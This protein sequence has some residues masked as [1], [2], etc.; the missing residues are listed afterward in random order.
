MPVNADDAL[1]YSVYNYA[2]LQAAAQADADA[3]LECLSNGADLEVADPAQKT[4]LMLASGRTCRT[5]PAVVDILLRHNANHRHRDARNRI[6]SHDAAA[7]GNSRVLLLLGAAGAALDEVDLDLNTPLHLTSDPRCAAILLAAGARCYVENRAGRTPL[8]EAVLRD[9]VPCAKVHLHYGA[10]P[11]ARNREGVSAVSLAWDWGLAGML[12]LLYG[13][14]AVANADGKLEDFESWLRSA[15]HGATLNPPTI[16]SGA[17]QAP[18]ADTTGPPRA[19]AEVLA[20]P[21]DRD[22]PARPYYDPTEL[23]R[24][25]SGPLDDERPKYLKKMREAG[26]LRVLRKVPEAFSA[27]TLRRDFPN[28]DKVTDFLEKQ[29][30]L[31][32]LAPS[33]VAAFQ[34]ILLLGDPGVGKTRYLLEVAKL[35]RLEFSLIQCGGVS[36]SFVLSGSTT[37]W[38]NGKPGKVHTTL[39]DGSSLNPFVVLDEIDKLSGSHDYDAH[40]PLYQLLEKKTAGRFQDECIEIPMDCSSVIW[41]ATANQLGAIP[42]AIVSRLTVIDVPPPTG[43]G[44]RQ[45]AR[46]VY[47]DILIEHS[48]TWGNRFADELDGVVLDLVKEQTPREIRKCLLGACGNA[49]LRHARQRSEETV[50]TLSPSDLADPMGCRRRPLGFA[51]PTA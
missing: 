16:V 27:D 36:A 2:L 20:L 14:S 18:G 4:P 46:S 11:L 37:S 23:D 47:R 43:E 42:E 25:L 3:V 31:C 9:D 7:A 17:V 5:A 29:V 15:L 32:R 1:Q 41:A 50:L 44:L 24:A 28:C 22:T 30:E 39:R 40:G 21:P 6:A 48:D 45:V 34:P 35:L 10:R 19:R 26:N 13:G 51:S 38:K 33:K 8:M 12:D 49:A